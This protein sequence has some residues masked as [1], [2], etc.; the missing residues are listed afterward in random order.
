MAQCGEHCKSRRSTNAICSDS[1]QLSVL[2]E[3]SVRLHRRRTLSQVHGEYNGAI[4]SEETSGVTVEPEDLNLMAKLFDYAALSIVQEK[5]PPVI[6][7]T[8]Q[9]RPEGSDTASNAVPHSIISASDD[10][11][12]IGTQQSRPDPLAMPE[13]LDWPS[14]TSHIFP[15]FTND[16]SFFGRPWS[17]HFSEGST[18]LGQYF[19][20]SN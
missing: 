4:P 6:N 5:I 19:D 15:D 9:N 18:Y 7:S 12:A 13:E 10:S 11:A 16:L 1:R 2:E 8:P 3:I 20:S 17:T 14:E